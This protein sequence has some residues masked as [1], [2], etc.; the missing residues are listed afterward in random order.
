MMNEHSATTTTTQATTA[1]HGVRYVVADVKRAIDFYTTRLGFNLEHQHLPMFATV[2]LGPLKIHL[3]GPGASGS[4]SLPSGKR[5]SP[6]GS[7]RVVLRVRDLP[8]VIEELR[9]SGAAFRNTMLS[10]PGGRQIQV[11]DPDGNPVELFEPAR[12]D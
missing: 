6:G 8:A 11:L 5:Q 10:G 1:F 9:S 3:S 7:N 4:R 2:A 12:R